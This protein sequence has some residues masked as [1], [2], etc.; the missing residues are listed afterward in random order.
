[1]NMNGQ[2]TLVFVLCLITAATSVNASVATDSAGGVLQRLIG[3]R[4]SSFQFRDIDAVDGEDV[5]EVDARDGRV[6]IA[7][8]S[9][10][11]MC[12]GAYEYLR[13]ACN[14]SVSWEGDH[15]DLPARFPDFDH[16]RVVCP[17]R[18]RHYFNVCTF[19]YTTVWWDWN[20]WQR[21]IDWMAL[22]GINQPLAM[23]GTEAIWQ[24]VWK[25]Y[26][27]SDADLAPFFTGPAFLPWHRMGNVNGHGGPLP[28]HWMDSQRELQKKILVRERELGMTPVTPAFS[29]FLPEAFAK[30]HP[31]SRIRKSSGWCGFEPTTLLDASD[32]LFVEIG[33]KFIREYINE[34]SSDHLYLADTFNEMRPQVKP[35]TKLQEL[36]ALSQSVFRSIQTGDPQGI[37]VMQGWLFYN[38]REFWK[39]DEVKALLDPIPDERMLLIDLACEAQ[40]TWKMHESFRRKNWLFCTLHNYGQNTPLQGNLPLYAGY[41]IDALGD[42]DH[43]RMSGMG[44]TPEGVEQNPV[45]YELLTDMMWRSEPVNLDQWL[46]DYCA[47]RYG[48]YPD[49]MRQAWDLLRQTVY[50][51]QS[52]PRRIQY[53]WRPNLKREKK[54]SA[55]ELSKL[56]KALQLMVACSDRLGSSQ[57]YQR[58]LVDVLKRVIE[59]RAAAAVD[60]ALNAYDSGRKNDLKA[61]AAQHD[62]ILIQLDRLLAARPEYQLSSRIKA[63][64]AC[65]ASGEEADLYERNARM[66]IT[67]WGGPELHDYA[68]KEWAGLTSSFYAPRWRMFFEALLAANKEHPF[69]EQAWDK[70]IAAWESDW[71]NQVGPIA[72]PDAADPVVIAREILKR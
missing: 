58:D 7:G 34:F 49:E 15:L 31:D 68:R 55:E 36:S 1:M 5:F 44:I 71:A 39:S 66:Q 11:A 13:A 22:H 50:S 42:R 18:Y 20:R 9:G 65:A 3:E 60:E 59:E 72:E 6:N 64:R 51:T 61:A 4:A 23:N 21:E 43:G 47:R 26:G 56:T 28:Q 62:A 8:S 37:W 19:G 29:G 48:A 69:D 57:L 32:P 27:L 41:E 24:R 16:R 53:T 45:V 10:V 25:S 17:N 52:F 14:A 46:A 33:A 67:I 70:K 40:Q 30:A 35:Q 38:D 12:R 54:A 2:A 63:A